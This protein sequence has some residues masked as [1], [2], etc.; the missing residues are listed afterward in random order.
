[1]SEGWTFLTNHARVLLCLARDPHA[2]MVDV[3]EQIGIRE[4]SVQQIVSD[5]ERGG[6]LRRQRSGRRNVYSIKRTARLRHAT[7]S[8]HDIGELLDIFVDDRPTS[9]K[10]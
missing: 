3:A 8:S 6:Y 10:T 7:E 1:M 5:L 2:R 9:R 4:R